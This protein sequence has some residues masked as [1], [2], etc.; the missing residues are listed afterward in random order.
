MGRGEYHRPS[1]EREEAFT[2]AIRRPAWAGK[3]CAVYRGR[4][5]ETCDEKGYILIS[6][7]FRDGDEIRISMELPAMKVEAHPY[8]SA[9][10]G[11]VALMRGPLLYCLEETDNPDGVEVTLGDGALT[12]SEKEVCGPARVLS[13]ICAD[14]KTFTAVPYYLWNNRGKGRMAVW[15]KQEGKDADAVKTRE[16]A[17]EYAAHRTGAG[18]AADLTGW[19]GR[20]YRRYTKKPGA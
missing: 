10:V 2:L 16:T 4:K 12:V 20:L 13:G 14:G 6:D 15:V 7:T 9:D 17:G 1:S 5:F 8:V 11:R 19:E 3:F 18:T